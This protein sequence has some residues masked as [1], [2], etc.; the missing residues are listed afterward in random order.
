[1]TA[2]RTYSHAHMQASQHVRTA[3]RRHPSSASCFR[4]PVCRRALQRFL[5]LL[6]IDYVQGFNCPCCSPLLWSERVLI[7]DAKTMGSRK[8]LAMRSTPKGDARTVPD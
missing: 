3:P 8:D 7:F 5:E 4:L 2:T 1:M 6:D